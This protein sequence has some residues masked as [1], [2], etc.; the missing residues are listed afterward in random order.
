MDIYASA[1][2]GALMSGKKTLASAKIACDYTLDCI[3]NTQ[4]DKKHWYGAKF[5]PSLPYLMELLGKEESIARIRKGIELLS[6]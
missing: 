6:K 2:V 1:F 5:E 4:G 3:K